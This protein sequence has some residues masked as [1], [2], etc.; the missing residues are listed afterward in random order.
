MSWLLFERSGGK[1]WLF[2]KDPPT[3]LPLNLARLPESKGTWSAHNKFDSQEGKAWP[4]GY[5]QIDNKVGSGGFRTDRMGPGYT[6]NHRQGSQGVFQFVV[7]GRSGMQIHSG[8]WGVGDQSASARR[9]QAWG[10]KPPILLPTLTEARKLLSMEP[11]LGC[12][13]TTEAAMIELRNQHN[14]EPIKG[15]WIVDTIKK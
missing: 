6:L 11:T 10:G 13:R 15:I 9:L 7:N 8:R 1:L 3:V 14:H 2:P 5:F 4:N 12:I